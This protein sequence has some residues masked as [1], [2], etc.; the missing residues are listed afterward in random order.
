MTGAKEPNVTVDIG[1]GA[2]AN[3]EARISTEIP[4]QS[5][6]RLLDS[7]TDMIRP[8]SERR[9]L[10]ADQIRLQREEVLIEI[11]R[12]ARE[13]LEIENQPVNPLPNKFLVP[14][15]EKAS[16][17][18]LGSVL[19][20][21]WA[22]L[23]ASCSAD[24]GSAHPRFVQ[25]LSEMT[26]A[27]ALLLRDI[28]FNSMDDVI[29]PNTAFCDCPDTYNPRYARHALEKWLKDNEQNIGVTH[30]ADNVPNVDV[31]YDYITDMFG[32]PGVSLKDI[33]VT[34]IQPNRYWSFNL[35]QKGLPPAAYQVDDEIEILCS[36]QLIAKHD[37]QIS[38]GRF[39]IDVYYVC[40]TELG[41]EFL[42]KCDHELE[43]KLRAH[44][45]C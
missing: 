11:A 33:T 44:P 34:E 1:L 14:F 22:D 12:K 35:R 32:S 43:Q 19:I 18:E 4:A 9:G 31:I 21:R 15:L 26:G 23:L 36:L 6:G 28:A 2:K 45:S 10:K 42:R 38:N 37:I 7:L 40:M 13:I 41:V 39:E 30:D 24:P 16:L 8:F 3:L 25:I 5:T 27:D 17:E 20:D 29:H